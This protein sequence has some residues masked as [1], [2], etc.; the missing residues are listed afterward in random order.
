[1]LGIH[2]PGIKDAQLGV[3]AAHHI[4]LSHGLAVS[5][6]R[7]N[8][9]PGT[10]VGIALDHSPVYPYDSRAETQQAVAQLDAFRNRWF[11]DP[12]FKQQYPEGLFANMKVSPPHIQ[13]GDFAQIGTPIDFLGLNYYTR[14]IVRG[15]RPGET[16]EN[17]EQ[18]D[19][20]AGSS[21]TDMGWEIYPDGLLA[22]LE[23]IR[24]DYAPP[25]ILITENGAAFPDR[26]D[27]TSSV[28]DLERTRYLAQHIERVAQ[29]VSNGIPVRGYF[30]WSLMDNYEWTWGY[31]KRFG[32]V[33]I[34][35]PSNQ[36]IIKESGY[37]YASFIDALKARS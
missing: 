22:S 1:V 15:K 16:R 28:V 23:R 29:A 27:G 17:Y 18:I 35:F 24:H 2:A 34:D 30:A 11:F 7:A 20:L 26:W 19:S 13:E 31:S 8:T 21:Y 5:R 10:Q 36:R 14:S 12:I 9:L 4:L 33:Y 3:H 37:W 32:L 6:I 25:A